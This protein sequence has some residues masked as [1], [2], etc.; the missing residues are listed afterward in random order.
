MEVTTDNLMVGDLL[1]FKGYSGEYLYSKV[2]CID[3][4][5]GKIVLD[6]RWV[7]NEQ[8]EYIPIDRDILKRLG[9]TFS[10]DENLSLRLFD[11]DVVEIFF[12][13]DTWN[14]RIHSKYEHKSVKSPIK[15]FH[16][17]QHGL[18]LL[19][20]DYISDELVSQLIG[21]TELDNSEFD[22]GHDVKYDS[23]YEDS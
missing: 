2:K 3:S 7:D 22:Y 15:Y 21:H 11:G 10:W 23:G 16:E 5:S 20:L 8:M 4:R 17:I 6:N 14:V 1:M 19:K 18:R 12:E 13:D 9:F